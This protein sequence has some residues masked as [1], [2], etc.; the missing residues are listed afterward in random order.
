MQLL[1]TLA[2]MLP[3][4]TLAASR[5]FALEGFLVVVRTHVPLKMHVVSDRKLRGVKR[6]HTFEVEMTSKR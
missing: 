4:K 2:V 6:S 1:V 3:R 5:P